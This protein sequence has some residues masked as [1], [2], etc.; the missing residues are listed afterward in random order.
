MFRHILVPLDRTQQAPAIVPLALDLARS[1][2]GVVVFA[3]VLRARDTSDR[4]RWLNAERATVAGACAL[5]RRQGVQSRVA[6]LRGDPAEQLVSYAAGNG[7]DLIAMAIETQTG[8][9]LAGKMSDAVMRTAPVP[10][11]VS[12]A[13]PPATAVDGTGRPILVV[14]DGSRLA[15]RTLPAA[16]TLAGQ[17]GASVTL[18]QVVDEVGTF[19]GRDTFARDLTVRELGAAHAY[20]SAVRERLVGAGVTI[21]TTV[22]LGPPVETV[23]WVAHELAAGIVAVS[24]H[25]RLGGRTR[26]DDLVCALR[27]RDLGASL[28]VVG[29]ARVPAVADG[30]ASSGTPDMT[31]VPAA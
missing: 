9:A 29:A 28:L 19:A 20:L 13:P 5:A 2:G 21:D 22:R 17:T 12:A 14:L 25:W 6:L 8:S 30:T 11:L 10:V 4:R 23:V 27:E 3:S 1:A 18:L 15:E 24:P 31:V 16:I 7:V 26:V